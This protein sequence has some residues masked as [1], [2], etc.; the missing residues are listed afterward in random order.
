MK[1]TFFEPN[2]PAAIGPRISGWLTNPAA[3]IPPK[4]IA[5]ATLLLDRSDTQPRPQ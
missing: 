2:E 1:K 5:A 3:A 4:L